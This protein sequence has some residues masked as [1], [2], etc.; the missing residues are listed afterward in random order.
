MLKMVN[1]A[2]TLVGI[3]PSSPASVSR[4]V[5]CLDVFPSTS[6]NGCEALLHIDHHVNRFGPN[7]AL[8][9]LYE[10]FHSAAWQVLQLLK[11]HGHVFTPAFEYF[12]YC[13]DIYDSL[14]KSGAASYITSACTSL[15]ASAHVLR[16]DRDEENDRTF[17]T[18]L[19]TEPYDINYI[20]MALIR[21]F[22]ACGSAA[23]EK[24]KRRA[25][26]L[27]PFS[28]ED[29]HTAGTLVVCRWRSEGD[30]LLSANAINLP[31]MSE[32]DIAA[33][34][35]LV[36]ARVLDAPLRT[37][38]IC[39]RTSFASLRSIDPDVD[40]EK[41]AAAYGGSGHKGASAFRIPA[42][43]VREIIDCTN[44]PL[45]WKRV[46]SKATK[47]KEKLVLRKGLWARPPVAKN[48]SWQE[49]YED[50]R[51]REMYARWKVEKPEPTDDT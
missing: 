1:P 24:A 5:I 50:M 6:M 12:V 44:F 28:L 31:T 43:M 47:K 37:F 21:G 30:G 27:M 17:T 3:N 8:T 4:H 42:D 10:E 2:M 32:T 41:I 26:F 29:A 46:K 20:T 11:A 18:T 39:P 15:G 35:I 49:K 22:E 9:E 48:A 7:S 13:V 40:V 25:F 14:P 33:V 51:F 16:V 36:A 19:F 34:E 38:L 23:L 45:G